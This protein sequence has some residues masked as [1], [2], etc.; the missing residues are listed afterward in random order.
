MKAHSRYAGVLIRLV[1]CCDRILTQTTDRRTDL[2]WLRVRD[3]GL[4]SA[5]SIAK[6]GILKADRKKGEEAGSKV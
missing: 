5:G 2:S 1:I 4:W 3:F 6:A